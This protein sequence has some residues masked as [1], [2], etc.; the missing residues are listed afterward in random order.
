MSHMSVRVR[1][2][3]IVVAALLAA[4]LVTLFFLTRV[5]GSPSCRLPAQRS[6]SA[7]LSPGVVQDLRWRPQSQID[8]DDLGPPTSHGA[9]F[10]ARFVGGPRRTVWACGWRDDEHVAVVSRQNLPAWRCYGGPGCEDGPPIWVTCY[11]VWDLRTEQRDIHGRCL[12]FP[13]SS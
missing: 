13:P 7:P 5:P 1:V 9:S 11:S 2:A 4:S 12:G 8:L 10:A 3:W 6:G